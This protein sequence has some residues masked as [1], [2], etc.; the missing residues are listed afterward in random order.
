MLVDLGAFIVLCCLSLRYIPW[1]KKMKKQLQQ[2]QKYFLEV[3][4][5]LRANPAFDEIRDDDVEAMELMRVGLGLVTPAK[6]KRKRRSSVSKVEMDDDEDSF[7]GSPTSKGSL[8][9]ISQGGS[10]LSFR[11]S[12]LSPIDEAGSSSDGDDNVPIEQ[13]K[14]KKRKSTMSQ[15]TI[16]EV[17]DEDEASHRP[18][19]HGDYE[20]STDDDDSVPIQA[21]KKRE[22]LRSVQESSIGSASSASTE[23]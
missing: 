4:A 20:D 11:S 14:L 19:G 6:K 1:I 12:N 17:E 15:L 3:E 7:T 16:P 8:R 13:L 9:R 23:M 10:V 21:L 18:L 2:L 5:A 22:S